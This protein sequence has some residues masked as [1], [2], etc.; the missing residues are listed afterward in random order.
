[1]FE[2]KYLRLMLLPLFTMIL[3]THSCQSY[4]D[5]II[6]HEACR[7]IVV[8]KYIDYKNH[9]AHTLWVQ[10]KGGKNDIF[11]LSTYD[12]D[13]VFLYNRITL[14]DSIIKRPGSKVYAVKSRKKNYTYEYK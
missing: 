2:V 11:Y 5:S 6:L 13:S 10:E 8:K 12:T 3:L 9:R 14:G 7:G 4:N 1:M